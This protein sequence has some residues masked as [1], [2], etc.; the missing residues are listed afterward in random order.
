[1]TDFIPGQ[2][3]LSESETELGL[4]IIKELDYRLV[5]VEYPAAEE[6]RTYAKGN[7]PLSRV[8]F[9][10]GDTIR[11]A[12]DLELV[13]AEVNELNGLKVYMAH[14]VDD[15]EDIQPVPEINLGHTLKLNAALDRLLSNQ[16]SSNRW[17]ELRMAALEAHSQQQQSPIQGLRGPRID[18]IGH[19]LYIA[20]Q[21]ANRFAP[22]VLLADE[23]GLGKTI[24]AGL[25]LHQQLLTG[26]ASR[27]L[28]VVPSPLVH[29]WFVEMVRRFNLHF[30]IFDRERLNALQPEDNI[31]DMLADIIAEEKGEAPAQKDNPFLSEQLVLCS[32]DF[33]SECDIDQ[34][35]A[36]DWDL[37]V[38]DEA[39]H[40]EWAPDAPS[41]D[42]QRVEAIA[43]QARGLLL[44]T[45]TPEQL[46]LESHYARLRLLDPDR[47]PS[48]AAFREEQAQYQ[49]IATL[50]GQLHDQP[51]WD[52]ALKAETA[53]LLPEMTIEESQ[54]EAILKELLDRSGPGRVM[55]RNSRHNIAGFPARHVHG[56]PLALPA[57]YDYGDD[58][59]LDS[60]LHPETLYH[61]DRWC[62][63]DPRVSWLEQFFKQHRH[64]KVL[65]ICASRH[66]A[67]DLHAH[68]NYKLGMNVAMFHEDMD[69]I[70]RDRAAA[71]FADEVDGAQALIC[72]EIGS[73]GRNFQ[74][75]HHLV[76]LDL[77]LNPD[78]L[79]Q[80]IG[81]LDR[82]GQTEDIQIHVP[83]FQ[84]HAQGVLFAW[85][86][87]GMNAF[88]HT[89][90]AGH[91]IYLRTREA[92]ED[93]LAHPQDADK[94]ATLVEQTRAITGELHTL[95]ET[96][97]DRLLELSSFNAARAEQLREQLDDAD[98]HSPLPF[99][100]RLFDRY[101][102]DQEE[103][104]DTAV[105]PKPGP[106]MR[107]AFPGL[108]EEGIT[109]TD[110]RVTA[111]ARDDMQFLTWEH[112]MV[113][114]GLE[115]V[116]GENRG[117]AAVSLLKNPKI[118]AGTLL[119][120]AIYT[121]EAVAPK[122]LQVDRFLPTTV[123]RHLLDANGKDISRA[124]SHDGLC[125]Q[126]H[127]MDKALSRKIVASQKPLLETLL[128]N[129]EAQASQAAEAVIDDARQAMRAE[130]DHELARLKAL[131]AKNPAVRDEEIAAL[132][133]QTDAL[134]KVLA[135]ARCQLNAVRVIVAGGE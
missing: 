57:D 135:E 121:I 71:F 115:M 114:G 4:G 32:T 73:E 63:L 134:E 60:H 50:A 89:N 61:D 20:D 16:L 35:A 100:Q 125:Q 65:V 66:T 6:E 10:A 17:F 19:Q 105:I 30:S 84:Q 59:G 58:E 24:E 97:R 87:Q 54:R 131:Q 120:E 76:L 1:M 90:P 72:S 41:G 26:R 86:H 119:I 79:E 78:L 93:A 55:F 23:V 56:V 80:R 122:H 130:Q 81:R 8:T 98:W 74:F 107:D 124:I 109:M 101:G 69:L 104:S 9:D 38:V 95:L 117:K 85:Y 113:T 106:H 21:V 128:K 96:G 12:N 5:T 67:T 47:Y 129:D 29:Q 28:V 64:E 110:D 116:L 126:C 13:V 43:R 92:L 99:M 62:S 39:H 11:T 22:R 82:I 14:P 112:P 36:A 51:N 46:G 34:L 108:P 3:W 75:A 102:V 40:L 15:P 123:I 37:M 48:L 118:K 44:L 42:Y 25:I 77:P 33:L 49:H 91:D 2:R 103:H 88:E 18:L 127:K 27:V 45:A 133:A 83:H 53:A 31:K 70:E 7:A 52:D 94:L 68:C 132:Q 111:L